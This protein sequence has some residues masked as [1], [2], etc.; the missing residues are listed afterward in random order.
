[1][2]IPL[3]LADRVIYWIIKVLIVSNIFFVECKKY[4]KL[5]ILTSYASPYETT[6]LTSNRQK[7]M[8]INTYKTEKPAAHLAHL[9]LP[10]TKADPSQNQKS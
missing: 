2:C 8:N 6:V 10:D 3:L 1:M 9:V 5:R 7:K 4:D